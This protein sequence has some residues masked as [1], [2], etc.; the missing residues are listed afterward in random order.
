V[1]FSAPHPS[2]HPRKCAAG[3]PYYIHSSRKTFWI[4]CLS[5]LQQ[6]KYQGKA[7]P[8]WVCASGSASHV[9]GC[10]KADH[11]LQTSSRIREVTPLQ[12]PS[13]P[14]LPPSRKAFTVYL[15]INLLKKNL[16]CHL[17]HLARVDGLKMRPILPCRPHSWHDVLSSTCRYCTS[18]RYRAERG[19]S[20]GLEAGSVSLIKFDYSGCYL[21]FLKKKEE[22]K[23]IEH[24]PHN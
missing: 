14:R 16:L 8:V 18:K 23:R 21:K 10:T 22:S 9:Q 24:V 6:K 20:E 12:I 15:Q 11:D 1:V 7:V 5:V 4:V 3:L 19:H 2:I 13:L 17:V